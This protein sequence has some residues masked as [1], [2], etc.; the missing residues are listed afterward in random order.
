M[1]RPGNNDLE[2]F[3]EELDVNMKFL[4]DHLDDVEDIVFAS[5]LCEQYEENGSLSQR[6]LYVALRFWREAKDSN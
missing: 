4:R 3:C 1:G 5:S 6:Q 2:V